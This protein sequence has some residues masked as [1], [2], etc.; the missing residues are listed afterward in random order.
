LWV[1][2]TL[3]DAIGYL[4]A[5]DRERIEKFI[6]TVEEELKRWAKETHTYMRTVSAAGTT[7]KEF[8]LGPAQ[9]LPPLLKSTVFV[10]WG[11]SDISE[12]KVYEHL[13]QMLKK[14]LTN[15]KAYDIFK[16][17]VFDSVAY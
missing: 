4:D 2:N 16:N 14:S 11:T 8:A 15:N 1:N 5:P 6:D 9:T 7:R 3:D 17:Q 10:F 12:P 13:L